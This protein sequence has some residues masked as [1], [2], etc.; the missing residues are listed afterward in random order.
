M[1]RINIF[2]LIALSVFLSFLS[3][4]SYVNQLSSREPEEIVVP[5]KIEVYRSDRFPLPGADIYLNQKFIGR[6]DETGVFSDEVRLIVGEVYTLRIERDSGGYVYGPWE[7]HFKAEREIEIKKLVRPREEGVPSLEG[8]FDILSEIERAQLGRASTYEKYHFL[9]IL[10]GYMYYTLKVTSEGG[11]PADNATVIIN[12]KE[13]GKT[14]NDGIF[15]VKYTGE[16]TREETIQIN[17]EGEHIWKDSVEI[18]PSAEIN[19]ELNKML[20]ID[21]RCIT[22]YYDVSTGIK[23]AEV[24]VVKNGT[25]VF[26]G[27]TDSEGNLFSKFKS[28]RGVDGPLVVEIKYSRGYV[29]AIN[30]R[31]IRVK[32]DMP[33]LELYDIS[34]YIRSPTPRISVFPIDVVGASDPYLIKKAEEIRRSIEDLISVQK[35]FNLTSGIDTK[36][37]LERFEV[38][39]KNGKGWADKPIVKKYVDAIIF[40][41]LSSENG[42]LNVQ[43]KSIDYNGVKLFEISRELTQRDIR[44]F[45]ENVSNLL[46][47]K[48]PFEGIIFDVRNGI[49]I[50]LGSRFGIRKGTSFHG[51]YERIGVSQKNIIKRKV[52]KLRVVDVKRDYSMCELVSVEEGFLVESGIKVKRYIEEG[53]KK[54]R[55]YLTIEIVSGKEPV[56]GANIYIDR[57]WIGQS[58]DKGVYK[59]RLL[60]NSEYELMVYKEGFEP[61]EK[62]IKTGETDDVLSVNI[63]RG[64]AVLRIDSNPAGAMVSVDG[65]PVGI[66]PLKEPI[67]VPYGFHLIELEKEGYKKYKNYIKIDRKRINFTGKRKIVLYRDYY[68]LARS[69]FEKGQYKEVIEVLEKVDARHPDYLKTLKLLGYIYLNDIKDYSKATQYFSKAIS[70]AEKMYNETEVLFLK[71]NLA[72]SY[73]FDGEEKYY[74][75]EFASLESYK[76]AI[77]NFNEVRLGKNLIPIDRREEILLDSIFYMAVSYQ[78]SYYLTERVEHLI[79]AESLWRDYFDFFNKELLKDSYFKNQYE[80]A[81]SYRKEIERLKGETH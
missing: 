39:Y 27:K 79:N 18:Y 72:L 64:I 41:S 14:D 35:V 63:R 30:E 19:I 68:S 67:T 53:V 55:I 38:D 51:Y 56:E 11:K 21:V 65:K 33:K 26:L 15:L 3:I 80:T 29:P 43:L 45:V 12:G 48:F 50:N 49:R 31:R 69:Y 61:F 76:N 40:G 23:D 5:I 52:A 60:S 6:S 81:E 16:D 34:F 8:E 58:N 47:Q 59:A 44:A 70:I 2:L 54:H 24:S 66:T 57:V 73:F 32:S 77:L 28:E 37:L 71:Y 42:K 74:I 7:T 25:K 36:R 78:K 1:N 4:K 10:D 17:K 9:A 20:L 13:E 75:N 62:L 46:L 22:E